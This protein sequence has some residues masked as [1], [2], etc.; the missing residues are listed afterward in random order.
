MINL[1]KLRFSIKLKKIVSLNDEIKN[2]N[3]KIIDIPLKYKGSI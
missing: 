2:Y 3:L 1:K